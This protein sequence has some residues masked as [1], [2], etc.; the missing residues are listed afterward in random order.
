[1]RLVVKC[2]L[3]LIVTAFLIGVIFIL[4]QRFQIFAVVF[5]E[6]N[7]SPREKLSARIPTAVLLWN[8]NGTVRASKIKKWNPVNLIQ[9]EN[10]RWSPRGRRFVFTRNNDVWLM[11]IDLKPPVKILE[12]VVTKHGTGAYWNETGE[13]IIAIR[14]ENPRQVIKLDLES[15]D[16][17]LIHDEGRPPFRNYPL[18]QGAHLRYQERY[19]LTFT[20]G[21][22]HRTMIIDLVDKKY[23]TNKLM[24]AGD[25]GPAWSPNGQ[26]LVMTRRGSFIEGRPLYWAEFDRSTEQVS[27]SSYLIGLGRCGNAAISNDSAYVAY[28]SAEN[29]FCWEVNRAV[30]E[31]RHGIQLTFDGHNDEPSLFIYPDKAPSTFN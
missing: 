26:F 12:N 29:I 19:L 16:I 27:P 24:R 15:G 17:H 31:K 7:L 13:S 18:S 3:G 20:L 28:A 9:G 11:R 1:M 23:I 4:D 2:L 6:K 22:G 30:K 14:R 10:P 8:H 25:C 21:D 5:S